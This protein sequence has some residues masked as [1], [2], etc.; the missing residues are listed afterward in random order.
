MRW[1]LVSPDGL[2]WRKF[3]DELVLRNART[4]DTH[5]LEALAAEVFEI[6]L[7]AGAAMEI[8]ELVSRLSETGQPDDEWYASVRAVLEEFQRLGLAEANSD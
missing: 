4:G 6:L 3:E 1:R 8:D 7:K 5:L 2:A